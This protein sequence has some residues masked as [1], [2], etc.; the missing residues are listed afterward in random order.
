MAAR[1]QTKG[2]SSMKKLQKWLF[3]CF[4]VALL[5]VWGSTY[6][7]GACKSPS[8]QVGKTNH[9]ALPNIFLDISIPLKDFAPDKLVCLAGV[10]QKRYQAPKVI[11]GI[12][13]SN[14]AAKNYRPLSVEYAKN[15]E[16]WASQQ[17]AIYLHDAEEHE[18]YIMLI[19][20][21]LSLGLDSPF[22]TR[23][24]IPITT[25]P[26]CKLDIRGRCLLAFEH[27]DLPINEEPGIVTF[28]AQVQPS[29]FLSGIEEIENP[30]AKRNP[31]AEFA[32]RNLK[33]WHFQRSRTTETIRIVYELE[34]VY[35]KLDNGVN[36]HFML[37]E[38]VQIQIGPIA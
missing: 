14:E 6:L 9:D 20:D 26:T 7:F 31:F 27:I 28:K 21:G 15:Q 8:Y 29:G 34:H 22:N 18:E 2:K 19:P 1:D 25:M 10:L 11:V 3:C 16:Q 13:S 17:H 33:S 32:L 12:F 30:S 24:D 36:V 35:R 5:P 4:L 38:R 37:P 23:I